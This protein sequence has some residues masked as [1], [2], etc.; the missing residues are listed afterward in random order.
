MIGALAPWHAHAS[1]V[2]VKR[3]VE[4][5]ELF[6]RFIDDVYMFAIVPRAGTGMKY[7]SATLAVDRS[8]QATFS[9]A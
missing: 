8:L 2:T 4:A 7:G 1:A 6:M 9:Y 5:R 3:A